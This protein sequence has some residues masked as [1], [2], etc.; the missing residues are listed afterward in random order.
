MTWIRAPNLSILVCQAIALPLSS[1]HKLP[2]LYPPLLC[3]GL[4]E[5][6]LLILLL[7]LRA[8]QVSCKGVICLRMVT[9]LSSQKRLPTDYQL[10]PDF[11]LTGPL[12]QHYLAEAL[13]L[14]PWG[15]SILLGPGVTEQTQGLKISSEIRISQRQQL[16]S[17]INI[18]RKQCLL[19]IVQLLSWFL[20]SRSRHMTRPS[21]KPR[22]YV[23]YFV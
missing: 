9:N 13:S 7:M 14:K 3:P 22:N 6:Q 4:S 8:G 10:H 5:W 21:P 16:H 15:F 17:T 20:Q 11:S 19:L 23:K 18:K 1:I 12:P 2:I